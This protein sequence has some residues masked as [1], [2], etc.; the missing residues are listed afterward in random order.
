[1]LLNLTEINIF[2]IVCCQICRRDINEK[3]FHYWKENYI[4]FISDKKYT[5][6]RIFLLAR[7]L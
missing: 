2:E 3:S 5:I 1:M 7:A 6:I 4:I